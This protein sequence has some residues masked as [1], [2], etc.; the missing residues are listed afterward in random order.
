MAVAVC[1]VIAGGG[2]KGQKTA[3]LF[4]LVFFYIGLYA[5]LC[6]VSAEHLHTRMAGLC[7]DTQP[8][9]ARSFLVKI[10]DKTPWALSQDFYQEKLPYKP[11]I[12]HFMRNIFHL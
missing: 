6:L 7:Y 10:P 3:L 9:E 5:A 11:L 12:E 8:V 4:G 1:S 2:G